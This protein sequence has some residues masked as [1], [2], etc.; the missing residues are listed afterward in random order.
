MPEIVA[1][2]PVHAAEFYVPHGG[3][4]PEPGCQAVLVEYLPREHAARAIGW[5]SVEA[6]LH[7]VPDVGPGWVEL[8]ERALAATG[9][10]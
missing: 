9:E 10:R 6:A 8:W 5:L 1:L 3:T 4:C 7:G 2:C